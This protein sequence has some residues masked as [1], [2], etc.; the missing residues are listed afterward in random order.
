MSI[1]RSKRKRKKIERSSPIK[2]QNVAIKIYHKHH[3][4]KYRDFLCCQ[5]CYEEFNDKDIILTTK[6][7]KENYHLLCYAQT[8]N[9]TVYEVPHCT[10]EL[11]YY[12]T[13]LNATQRAQV[14]HILFPNMISKH[15]RYQRQIP[16]IN[17]NDLSRYKLKSLAQEFDIDAYKTSTGKM[18]KSYFERYIQESSI[19]Y[20]LLKY[21]EHPKAKMRNELLIFSYC[22][23]RQNEYDLNFPQ[24]LIRIVLRFFPI[25]FK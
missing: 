19:K 23:R 17:L 8:V 16:V 15:M 5:D 2:W 24:Y 18:V 4:E 7:F 21:C 25:N 13:I 14:N 22:R 6:I 12:H 1:V 11:K 10:A 3:D 20:Q 9:F